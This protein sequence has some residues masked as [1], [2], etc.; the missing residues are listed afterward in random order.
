L[1]VA[2]VLGVAELLFPKS[3]SKPLLACLVAALVWALFVTL[4]RYSS[5][6]RLSAVHAANGVLA[7]TMMSAGHA[8]CPDTA[9]DP[10]LTI[11]GEKLIG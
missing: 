5:I 1:P 9:V 2:I 8:V 4:S 7:P 10:M 6:G 3:D 11:V